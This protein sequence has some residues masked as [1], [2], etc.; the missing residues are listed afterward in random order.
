MAIFDPTVAPLNLSSL[1]SEASSDGV[2]A[3][4]GGGQAAAFQL[5]AEINRVITVAASGDSVRL[6]ASVNGLTIMVTNHGA[7]PMQVYGFGTDTI[8]DVVTAT[9]VS[10]MPNSVVLYVC[11]TVGAW[12]AEGLGNGYSGS[13]PTF[14][15]T[16]GITAFST[17]G[18]TNAVPLVSVINR[19]TTVA[20]AA[21]SVKLPAAVAGLSI[22][23]TNAA[24]ANAM[25]VFPATGDIINALAANTALSIVA[26]KTATFTCAVAGQWHSVLTA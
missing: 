9:G 12:Y 6:P 4:S 26:N 3:H 16:N 18:Q 22:T 19:V 21:D 20:A 1:M 24:A 15:T 25:N 10:Q 13:F 2:V 17:G 23:V 5:L 8:N 7:N 14:S 11:S